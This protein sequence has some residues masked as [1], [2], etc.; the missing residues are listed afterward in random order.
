MP[1]K[2]RWKRS[3]DSWNRPTN[4]SKSGLIAITDVQEARAA[5][6]QAVA[7]VIQAKRDAGD[8]TRI[9]ARTDRRA[10]RRLPRRS[11]DM[12]LKSPDPANEEQ[13]VTAALEQN[14]RVISARL[15][16]DIAKQDVRVAR[17]GHFPAIDMVAGR[18]GEST[19]AATQT[20]TNP[21]VGPIPGAPERSRRIA[22]AIEDSSACRSRLPIYSGGAHVIARSPTRVSAPRRTR[23]PRA[24]EPRNRA[25]NPRCLSRRT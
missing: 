5:H 21:P 9:V 1:P 15:A 16:T 8:G 24:H 19:S 11:T 20:I 17:S 10:V 6:D 2:R 13:W 14:L 12:P 22:T 23:T 18:A 3:A 7:A 4:A 25:C